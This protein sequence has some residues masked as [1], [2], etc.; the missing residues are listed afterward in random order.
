LDGKP[1]ESPGPALEERPEITRAPVT[2]FVV[3]FVAGLASTLLGIGGGLLMVPSMVWMLRIRQHRAVGTSLAVILPTA[4][5]AAYRYDREAVA[6]HLP[7]LDMG[8]ILWLA[9]GGVIGAVFGAKLAN[10]IGAKQ[11]RRMFGV[12]V[13]LVGMWMII[14]HMAQVPPGAHGP[15]DFARALE[16]V[17]VGVLVGVISGLLGVGGG[18][19]M[20]PALALIVGYDQHLAQGTSL[21]VIIPV[22]IS[23][24]FIHFLRG[25]VIWS[26]TLWLAI[27]A[28]LGA[29]IMAGAVFNIPKE[30][31]RILFGV[32]LIAIGVSMANTR[33]ARPQENT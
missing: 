31:L 27:G 13:V 21:A 15:V 14:R 10:A 3:G 11:L 16:L 28:V 6:R 23:G 18:L 9:L 8:V 2:A 12:F 30:I 20:V 26:L 17:C 25:N 29:W 7:G 32:F 4:I 24:A 5:A 19:V 22:S 1:A 33:P